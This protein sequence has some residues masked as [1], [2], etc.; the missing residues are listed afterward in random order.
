MR[1][2]LK[3]EQ[4]FSKTMAKLINTLREELKLFR[5]KSS[6]SNDIERQK[7]LLKKEQHQYRKF[8]DFAKTIGWLIEKAEDEE[9]Y[10]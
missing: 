4:E 9:E 6:T 2:R 7:L 5:K 1:R 10:E 3:Q 8:K